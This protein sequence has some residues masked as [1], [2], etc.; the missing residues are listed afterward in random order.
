MSLL[1]DRIR[2]IVKAPPAAAAPGPGP[3]PRDLSSLDGEWLDGCFT[4]RRRWAPAAR[5]G[6]EAIGT[7]AECLDEAATTAALFGAGARAPFAFFDLETTGLSG[8][9]GTLAFL[10]G[11]GSFQDGGGFET[12]QFLLTTH[13][14][15][16]SLL[17]RVHA[18]LA[19]A[20]A[21]VSFN[22]K[23]FD[24]P[25]LESRFAY[26]RLAR[27]LTRQPHLDALHP[28]RQF[29]SSSSADCSLVALERR[30]LGV[31][32]IGDVDGFEVPARYFQFLRSGDAR[33]L[34]A[35]LEHNRLD[36]LT[37]AALTARLLYLARVGPDAARTAREAIALGRVYT[38][39]DDRARAR[40]AF[41]RGV[42]LAAADDPSAIVDALRGLALLLR[43]AR[44]Y[45]DA[46]ACW[47]R[48]IDLRACP[49]AIAREAAEALAIH[50]EHRVR[51]LDAA[52]R[53]ALR[54]L[55]VERTPRWA[56]GVRCRVARIERK[57]SA[58]LL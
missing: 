13:A 21:I 40:D 37:L 54:S 15:E 44:E 38:R 17:E 32:R 22:G 50:H 57:L 7:F 5:H 55:E 46:A 6:R 10:V 58:R 4:V 41:T 48:L 30:L 11:C 23:S 35:V 1:T 47:R 49:P 31:T 45:A 20:G 26:H 27:T 16:R 53:F 12:K 29:W 52:K 24:A 43:R 18:E 8:G 19:S 3:G 34:E 28:A 51:D 14:D 42:E 36:L 2:G 39:A 9:A 33:P 25:L 56:D